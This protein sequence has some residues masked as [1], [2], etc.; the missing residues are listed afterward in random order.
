MNILITENNSQKIDLMNLTLLEEQGI[1]LFEK[2]A[3]DVSQ[4]LKNAAIQKTKIENP[5]VSVP[6]W[7]VTVVED[8]FKELNIKAHYTEDTQLYN[9]VHVKA[10]LRKGIIYSSKAEASF[11]FEQ[12]RKAPTFDLEIPEPVDQ[13]QKSIIFTNSATLQDFCKEVV[14][15]VQ[16]AKVPK[17]SL[18]QIKAPSYLV[19]P[20]EFALN[21]AGW[22][23][24]LEGKLSI[25]AVSSTYFRNIN[26]IRNN[27][28]KHHLIWSAL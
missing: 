6:L 27:L 14:K 26:K 16:S 8:F 4:I 13:V 15:K 21:K 5:R 11:D 19:S 9:T 24:V 12:A 10:S 23:C 1:F 2:V 18:I 7:G 28:P 25:S 17:T 22:G 20:I 3:S